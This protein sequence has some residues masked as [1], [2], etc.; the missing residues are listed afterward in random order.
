MKLA[1][2]VLL[3]VAAL[4]GG[5]AIG[6]VALPPG[7]VVAALLHPGAPDSAIVWSLRV[8]RAL[9]A[10][11]VGGTLGV[12]GAALQALVRNPLAEP[13]LLGISGGAG[14]AAVVAIALGMA[15]GWLLP[16]L[17]FGGAL[18]ASAAVY[19]LSLVG[20]QRLEP[21]TLVLAGVVV[22]FFCGAIMSALLTQTDAP[23]L[24]NAFL[25][26]LGGF[27]GASWPAL[28]AFLVYA[29]APLLLL[30]ATASSLD[31]LSLGDET[32]HALGARVERTKRIVYFTTALLT[33][34]SVAVS[35]MIG[36]VGLIT[37]HAIRGWLG[38]IH[39]RLL[40]AVF[41]A[42]GTLLVA[43]DALAR[44]VV[45]PAE[46]P[47]GAVTALIGVPVFAWLLRRSLV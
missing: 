27:G 1:L 7:E 8:P 11:A 9:L 10:F 6:A 14:L 38:S 43:A 36:F 34:A 35:G 32:A 23:R 19:R 45:R 18:V 31:L 16:A 15:S 3:G 12:S 24:R 39:R 29:T 47:V 41:L 46:L 17:A 42:S 30:F 28:A 33:A 25:W 26:L 20:G 13:Y 5:V 37:P 2:L 44:T 40:P 21:R 4:I 22:A